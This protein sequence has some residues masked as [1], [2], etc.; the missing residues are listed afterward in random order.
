MAQPRAAPHKDRMHPVETRLAYSFRDPKLLELALTHASAGISTE[1]GRR[2]NERLEFLGDTVLDLIIAEDLYGDADGHAEGKLTEM[3]AAVVSR[4]ALADA[5]RRLDLAL[6]ARLG[7]GLAQREP[8]RAILANL[9]EALVGAIYLDGGL[10]AAREFS[11]RTL[12]VE[13]TEARVRKDEAVP[14]QGLQEHC[15][16][17]F[18]L[19]PTYELVE[20]RGDDHARAFLVRARAGERV[21]PPAWG[22][23]M[24]EAESWAAYEALL[25]LGANAPGGALIATRPTGDGG[26]PDA[27]AP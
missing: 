12:A 9:F 10:E 21:Y 23:T 27:N 16:R 6:A 8:S 11:L 17:A 22:R 25:V 5:A 24:K 3:K 20:R 4:K 7:R 14:K 19:T 2:D 13:L 18:G 1:K 15:Q 26:A